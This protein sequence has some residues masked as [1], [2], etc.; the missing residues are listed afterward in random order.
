MHLLR[1]KAFFKRENPNFHH[2][3]DDVFAKSSPLSKSSSQFFVILFARGV[4]KLFLSSS[5]SLGLGKYYYLCPKYINF[6][7]A[8]QDRHSPKICSQ[9]SLC[10]LYLEEGGRESIIF[11]FRCF[12]YGNQFQ[13]VLNLNLM[14]WLWSY[15]AS[16]RRDSHSMFAINGFLFLSVLD[17]SISILWWWCICVT[18]KVSQG[19]S[20]LQ[21]SLACW[22]LHLFRPILD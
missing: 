8:Q 17:E 20:F 5:A 11:S 19:D 6:P 10:S 18:R 22:H 9:L 3:F 21:S 1:V 15:S 13:P 12:L 16:I 4:L 7:N 2:Q 14:W